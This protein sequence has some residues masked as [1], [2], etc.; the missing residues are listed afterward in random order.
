MEFCPICYKQTEKEIWK[1]ENRFKESR[2]VFCPNHGYIKDEQQR[3]TVRPKINIKKNFI[4]TNLSIPKGSTAIYH[5]IISTVGRVLI[6]S[7]LFTTISLC[8]ILGYFVGTSANN[9]PQFM[10]SVQVGAF[11]NSSHAMSLKTLLATK[12]YKA[13]I[14]GPGSVREDQLYR[15][16][17]GKLR[18][19]NSAEILSAKIEAT[20]GIQTFVI[21]IQN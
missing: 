9:P 20:E 7:T 3:T 21:S 4:R 16:C 5:E 1:K 11:S 8:F 13:D 17:I 18:D 12:G 2:W 15:V 6:M 10:Y 19:R 14:E